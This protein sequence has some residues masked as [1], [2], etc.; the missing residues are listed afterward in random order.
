MDGLSHKFGHDPASEINDRLVHSSL[1]LCDLFLQA[2]KSLDLYES[3]KYC[4]LL[5]V[6]NFLFD[7]IF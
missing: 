6:A 7:T 3:F 2:K 4:C 1:K 5:A